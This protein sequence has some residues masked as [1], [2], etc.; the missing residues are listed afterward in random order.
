MIL[1]GKYQILVL[2]VSENIL[3]I[4]GKKFGNIILDIVNNLRDFYIA[5]KSLTIS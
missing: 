2:T 3:L 5:M 4:S 1:I